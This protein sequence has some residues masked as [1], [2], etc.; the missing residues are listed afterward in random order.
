MAKTINTR[1][2]NPKPLTEKPFTGDKCTFPDP[3]ILLY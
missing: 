3:D 2:F 1:V